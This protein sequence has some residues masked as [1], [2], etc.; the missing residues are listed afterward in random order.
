MPIG[1]NRKLIVGFILKLSNK[2]FIFLE[3]L[4]R[5]KG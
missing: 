2:R 4:G 1:Q 5:T 3:K